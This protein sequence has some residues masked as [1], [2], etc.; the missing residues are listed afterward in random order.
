MSAPLKK[1]TL[2]QLDAAKDCLDEATPDVEGAT[3]N[4]CALAAMLGFNWS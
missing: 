4:L 2:T 1:L 3:E